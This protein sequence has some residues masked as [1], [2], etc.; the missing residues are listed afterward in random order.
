MAI[1]NEDLHSNLQ[2]PRPET[3]EPGS[4]QGHRNAEP[5][6]QLLDEEGA[7][8]LQVRFSSLFAIPNS[9]GVSGMRQLNALV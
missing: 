7:I 8:S 5:G 3:P 2:S 1:A 4:R 6:A 9:I